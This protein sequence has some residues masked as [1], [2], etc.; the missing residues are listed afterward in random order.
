MFVREEVPFA[1]PA[2]SA[3]LAERTLWGCD[4]RL[5]PHLAQRFRRQAPCGL[6][7]GSLNRVGETAPMHD[8]AHHQP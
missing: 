4:A 5:A 6:G 8:R 3:G 2:L 1:T 7:N